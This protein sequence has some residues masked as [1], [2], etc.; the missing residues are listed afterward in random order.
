MVVKSNKFIYSILL[1]LFLSLPHVLFIYYGYSLSIGLFI[2]SIFLYLMK[3]NNIEIKKNKLYFFIL[4]F[5][6]LFIQSLFFFFED[7]KSFI[8]VFL[9]FF[10]IFGLYL[11]SKKLNEK[12]I[13]VLDII[14]IPLF[15][16]IFFGWI[17]IIFPQ[18]IPYPEKFEKFVFPFSEQSHYALCTGFLTI[19]YGFYKNNKIKFF[20]FLNLM[21]QAIIF[22]SLTLMQFCFFAFF[23]FF[24]IGN[25]YLYII[26]LIILITFFLLST[27][28]FLQ[29]TDNYFVSR[30]MLK[31]TENLSSLVY[32]QGI[33]D[34]KNALF[35]T[36]GLGLGFQRAG[37]SE[38][39]EYGKLILN[40]YN[41]V[42]NREDGGFLAAK[43]V[44]EF[45][46]LGVFIVL[47][48]A[49]LFVK[50]LIKI[51]VSKKNTPIFNIAL[52]AFFI[53]FFFRG[54]GYFSPQL[55]L[56][57][58]IYFCGNIYFRDQ[59]KGNDR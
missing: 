26:S 38:I 21:L 41:L 28:F 3:F 18:V 13:K 17:S 50:S 57:I 33:D 29:D 5:L 47:S 22:P 4:I 40:S 55:L 12:G 27:G 46:L 16:L 30:I 59:T 43:I 53:E 32:L 36:N 6:Y 42:L 15:F 39:G 48:Y 31:D 10:I 44:I 58:L 1:L 23:I 7:T 56:L 35:S 9:I 14:G 19:V 52:I 51:I 8:S 45:G 49:S 24:M 34:A 11:L 54:I 37:T 20:L 25:I 2:I